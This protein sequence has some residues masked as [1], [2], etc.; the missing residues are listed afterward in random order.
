MARLDETLDTIL[1]RRKNADRLRQLTTTSPA[2]VDFSSNDYLSLATNTELQREIVSR[3]E[4]RILAAER[5]EAARGILGSG[6]SR[7]LD[8]NSSFAEQLEQKMADFHGARSGLLFNSAYDANVGLL[9][10]VPQPGD[11]ILYDESIHASVH[12]GMRLS[13]A[14][15]KLPFTHDSVTDGEIDA[16]RSGSMPGLEELLRQVTNGDEG[17]AAREGNRNVFICVEGIYSMDG[18]VAHLENVTRLTDQ[19]LPRR[20]GYIIVDEAHSVGVLGKQ[21]RGL[22]CELGLESK[23][24]ARVHGFGK[25]MGCA[26]GKRY[27]TNDSVFA[28]RKMTF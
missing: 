18:T 21:G 22:V 20:N 25:A 11:I 2:M 28:I 9:S 10:C 19:C 27:Y 16:S 5:G 14:A 6:G 3:L 8:G 24:W 7:L 13:R 15:T 4:G 1:A 17:K 12:E 26:G 23:I